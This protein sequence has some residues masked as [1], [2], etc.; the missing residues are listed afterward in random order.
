GAAV[1]VPLVCVHRRQIEPSRSGGNDELLKS[2]AGGLAVADE[3]RLLERGR[4][5]GEVAA[6]SAGEVQCRGGGSEIWL[7]R[8]E[9]YSDDRIHGGF[10][11]GNAIFHAR[12]IRD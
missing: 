9:E 7:R 1:V 4:D 10:E 2:A 6:G 12:K 5:R 11:I 3:E 8:V